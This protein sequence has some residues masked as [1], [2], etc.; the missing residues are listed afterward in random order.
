MTILKTLSILILSFCALSCGHPRQMSAES[1]AK[2]VSENS[3][4]SKIIDTE[5][6]DIKITYRP[7]DLLIAQGSNGKSEFNAIEITK[8]REKYSPYYYFI[9]SY[10]KDGH[11][12]LNASTNSSDTFTDLLQTISFRM[13]ES[14]NLTTSM[15]DTIPVADYIHNRTFGLSSST[16]LLFVFEN[17]LA[18]DKEWIQLNLA[19]MGLGVGMQSVQFNVDDL[20]SAPKIYSE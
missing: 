2:Y 10:T 9:I 4:Y 12:L 17:R 11:E 6:V 7:I 1:L 8:A 5:S 13:N 19:E 15:R 16:D 18:R 14:V 20:E 3:K